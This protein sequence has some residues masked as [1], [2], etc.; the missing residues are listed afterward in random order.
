M[1]IYGPFLF[2]RLFINL[3]EY[4]LSTHYEKKHS[5]SL[6]YFLPV[7]NGLCSAGYY[8]ASTMPAV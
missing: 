3:A 7:A 4:P 2:Y 6:Y 8:L 5:L 1:K